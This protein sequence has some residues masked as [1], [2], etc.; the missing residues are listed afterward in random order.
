ME[1]ISTIKIIY[2]Y[3]FSAIGLI[4]LIIGC[5]R[6][7]DMG[8]KTFLFKEAIK[9]E[10]L[11]YKRPPVDYYPIPVEKI[12]KSKDFSEQEKKQLKSLAQKYQEWQKEQNQIDY[13]KAKREKDASISLA[14]ILVGFPLY[15]YHWYIARR[16]FKK[17]KN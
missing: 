10:V 2:I 13:L 4:L 6:F 8:L 12:E 17:E 1:K 14:M 7:I 16:D 5:I 15:F 3:L 9:E 11:R